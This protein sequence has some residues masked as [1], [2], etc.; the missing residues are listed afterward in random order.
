MASSLAAMPVVAA[1]A[2]VLMAHV[3]VADTTS[4]PLSGG[5]GDNAFLKASIVS[6]AEVDAALMT[7]LKDMRALE[8][9]VPV[10]NADD[11]FAK[12]KGDV[13]SSEH[14]HRLGELEDALSPM[15]AA[16]PKDK[17][18]SLGHG[19]VRYA[20]HRLLSA[21]HGWFVKGLEPE[22]APDAQKSST[23][24]NFLKEWV[25]SH[26]QQFLETSM[27]KHRLG[28]HE[29]AVLAATVEDV[30]RK[31]AIQRLQAVYDIYEQKQEEEVSEEMADEFIDT[32]VLV[33]HKAG[34]FTAKTSS[35]ATKRVR[36]F[37]RKFKSG[38][39]P[40][41]A[42]LRELRKNVTHPDHAEAKLSFGQLARVI[43]QVGMKYAEF[44]S[45]FCLEMKDTLLGLED[46]RPGR[47]LLAD[48]Y[49]KALAAKKF[50]FTEKI[51]YLRTLG[52]LDESD[53]GKPRVIIPNYV[54][55]RPQCLEASGFYAICC[56]N[57]CEELMSHLEKKIANPTAKPKRIVEI[58]SAMSTGTVKAPRSLSESIIA[59]LEQVA[60]VHDGRVPLHGRLFAQWMH[61]AF[62][63]ECPFPHA[64]GVASPQTPDEWLAK[65]GAE[66]H[67]ATRDEMMCHVD[68]ECAGG[69]SFTPAE[70]AAAVQMD[71]GEI[72]WTDKEELQDDEL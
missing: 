39:D 51:D 33:Y 17:D 69:A 42:W 63:R 31:E 45:P 70:G 2:V 57:Q 9:G 41:G 50:A 22:R 18:G 59:R 24:L 62:P 28:L 4:L 66:T 47:V 56:V 32:F 67:E 53:P 5:P 20:L 10:A 60:T 64:M 71:A 38:W 26:I 61:H 43:D 68:G 8:E 58:V 55:S 6:D 30:A 15:Y 52:A 72:P 7:E 3:A 1:L 54:A 65:S 44:N 13:T 11:L 49:R 29:V 23:A 12:I 35:E 14:A 25:P 16:L 46:Q 21:E 19:S 48:F 34:N 27:G 40:F 37:R 36:T